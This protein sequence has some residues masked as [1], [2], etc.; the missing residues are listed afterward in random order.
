MTQ[1]P[2]SASL[3]LSW[4]GSRLLLEGSGP[5]GRVKHE[6]GS[7]AELPL[8]LRSALDTALSQRKDAQRAALRAVEASNIQYVA[9]T[10]SIRFAKKIWPKEAL[11]RAELGF[12]RALKRLHNTDSAPPTQQGR[13]STKTA[14]ELGL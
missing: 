4:D 7:F 1:H 10:H 2:P 14:E 11:E 8:W 5:A 13:C 3:I 6:V 12:S 9:E